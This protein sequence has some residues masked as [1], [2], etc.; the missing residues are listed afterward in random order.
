LSQKNRADDLITG[1]E[2]QFGDSIDVLALLRSTLTWQ[3]LDS[4]K[5][6]IPNRQSP[7]DYRYNAQQ[8]SA[9]LN[10]LENTAAP[11]RSSFAHQLPPPSMFNASPSTDPA[12]WSSRPSSQSIRPPSRPWSPPESTGG[13]RENGGDTGDNTNR[14]PSGFWNRA[15]GRSGE[16]YGSYDSRTSASRYSSEQFYRPQSAPSPYGLIP[17]DHQ[18]PA[19][20]S[21]SSTNKTVPALLRTRVETPSPTRSPSPTSPASQPK[22]KKRRV[23]LSCAEC[24]K[25][26][27]KCNREIP[28][29]HC[30]ARRVPELCVPYSRPPDLERKAGI[31]ITG[32]N[33]DS[34][35]ARTPSMLP[36]LSVRVG[37]IEALLNA[38][39]NRVNGV[40]GKAL[41][42][43]RISGYRIAKSLKS[44]S[45]DLDHAPAEHPPPLRNPRSSET[46]TMNNATASPTSPDHTAITNK[47]ERL[48][49]EPEA[50]GEEIEREDTAEVAVVDLLERD[51][52]A[53]NPL[54]QSVSH[55][56]SV[57]SFA[58]YY[59]CDALLPIAHQSKAQRTRKM[60]LKL[61]WITYYFQTVGS[62]LSR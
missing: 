18:P 21:S 14:G 29:Q 36:T 32:D 33:A 59:R 42:D 61:I 38:M 37:R 34:E 24:A 44:L 28:C 54:P 12:Y 23:A 20:A 6:M 4:F 46:S 57:D 19:T 16:P 3:L 62:T 50:R 13:A 35:K 27:Q 55:L 45:L 56:L 43:W 5:A 25:R 58:K 31:A 1:A 8:S 22:Q 53:R 10:I 2:R 48:S 9:P 40:E 11:R 49:A 30:V 60:P 47:Q 51:T 17:H 7:G 15:G 52:L 26:K 41:D 39:V